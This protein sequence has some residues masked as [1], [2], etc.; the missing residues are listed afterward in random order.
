MASHTAADPGC[1][2]V[3]IGMTCGLDDE[4]ACYTSG[5]FVPRAWAFTALTS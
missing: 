1:T 4:I 3:H 5:L 2:F